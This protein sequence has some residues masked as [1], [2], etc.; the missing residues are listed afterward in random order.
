VKFAINWIPQIALLQ[1]LDSSRPQNVNLPPIV[2]SRDAWSESLDSTAAG[3]VTGSAGAPPSLVALA[4]TD[5]FALSIPALLTEHTSTHTV[6]PAV[7][8]ISEERAAGSDNVL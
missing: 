2:F 4:A 1:E 8:A 7:T 5:I 3:G 6:E